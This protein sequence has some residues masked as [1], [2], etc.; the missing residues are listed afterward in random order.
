MGH[1]ARSQSMLLA[2]S[3]SFVF[4]LIVCCSSFVLLKS[5]GFVYISWG[6]FQKVG[7]VYVNLEMRETLLQKRG[8]SNSELVAMVID[9]HLLGGRFSTRN[10]EF[11]PVL[12][13]LK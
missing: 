5:L 1:S 3:N 8:K 13:R 9:C 7:Y 11:L 12:S 6:V 4:G 10:P 2:V